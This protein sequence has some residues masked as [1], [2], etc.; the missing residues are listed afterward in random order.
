MNMNSYKEKKIGGFFELE[1]PK[2]GSLYHENAIKLSTGRACLN[3]ILQYVKPV[4]VYLPYYCCNSLFE[5]MILNNISYE[6]YKIDETL[7]IKEL[8]S[9]KENEYL[10][11][12][13]F[14]GIKSKYID[15]LIFKLKNKIIIDNTHSFFH[16]GYK[17][18]F[19]FTSARKY[20]GVPDGAFLYGPINDSFGL[21]YGRNKNATIN[22]NLL[23]LIGHQ[24]E[25][26]K[27]YLKYEESLGSTIE[28]ISIVSENLLSNIDYDEVRRVRNENYN[29]LYR[30]FNND[31]KLF[32][33]ENEQDYFCYP[34]LL[35]KPIDKN[36]LYAENIFIPNLW[37][38]IVKRKDAV[39]YKFERKLS[40]ELLPLP[41][42]HRHNTEDLKRM[43]QAIRKLI[44]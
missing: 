3:Y 27:E 43:V 40:T 18:N 29:Y 32:I 6:F 28:G 16:K 44:K 42:D 4:K 2:K 14:F 36:K 17:D 19:S 41:I 37:I 8:P 34:L 25:A 39:N 12:C 31:N 33:T 15:D 30:E 11:Y 21:K 24:E 20:F 38:E 5:P 9:L 1:I 26:F 13:D 22:H 35:E 10:I 7:E 23:S